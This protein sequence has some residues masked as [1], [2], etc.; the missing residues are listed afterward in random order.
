M[1]SDRI[2]QLLETIVKLLKTSQREEMFTDFSL[3]KLLA[4]CLQMVV[5]IVSSCGIVVSDGYFA[6][7]QCDF[8]FAGL[9]DSFSTDGPDILYCSKPQ[10]ICK[11]QGKIP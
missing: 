2:E 8:D 5:V 6:Q 11:W 4:G 10:V 9:C 3:G 1:Y 7:Y